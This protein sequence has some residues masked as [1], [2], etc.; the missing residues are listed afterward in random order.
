MS[1]KIPL[2]CIVGPTASGKTALGIET[3][4][5]FGG[6]VVSAD[7]MQIYRGV[8]I[9]G[10]VPDTDEMRGIPHHLI[11]F[12][13]PGEQ[14]SVADYTAA[15][16]R[17]ISDI[18]ARGKLPV[19]VGGTGLYI[20]SLLTATRFSEQPEKPEVRR[21][22]TEQARLIGAE[23]MH[24][25]LEKADPETAR[26]LHPNDLKR[27]IRALEVLELTGKP[28]SEWLKNSRA[29]E[30][31]YNALMIGITFRD[32]QLLYERI[33]RRVDLMLERGLESEARAA[34][35]RS[36]GGAAQAI[37]HKEFFAY[38]RGETTLEQAVETLKTATRRYAKR[39]LT[40]FRKNENINWIYAD[41]T[42]N[43]ADRAK[44]LI[45]EWSKGNEGQHGN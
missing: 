19:L 3:A 43:T 2:V 38:F 28:L 7:S 34:F 11:E 20:D 10:A 29:E 35:E 9:A 27:V 14:F 6:E 42:A 12:K 16:R 23:K 36:G 41:E 26:R 21:T 40:W 33:N 37:G 17:V 45:R 24:E 22:L 32:R 25:R 1:E 31:P 13:E 8:H 5:E 39:Q 4:R 30:C 18:S 15:A 44:E